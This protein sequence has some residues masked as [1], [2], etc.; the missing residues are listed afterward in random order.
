MIRAKRTLCS[1]G[2]DLEKKKSA[3]AT[4]NEKNKK[5]K[6]GGEKSL[7]FVAGIPS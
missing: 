3:N 2:L 4:A 6:S 7:H 5:N 1:L